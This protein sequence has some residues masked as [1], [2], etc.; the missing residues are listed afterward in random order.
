M[1]HVCRRVPLKERK[2]GDR[3]R[4]GARGERRCEG[5]GWGECDCGCSDRVSKMGHVCRRVPL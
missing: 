5:V 3:E 1:G 2:W 4:G